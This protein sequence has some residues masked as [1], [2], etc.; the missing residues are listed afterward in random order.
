M[1]SMREDEERGV[2]LLEESM[3]HQPQHVDEQ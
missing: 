1:N 2:R 3:E